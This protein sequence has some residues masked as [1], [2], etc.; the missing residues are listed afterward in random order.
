[1]VALTGFAAA[2]IGLSALFPLAVRAAAEHGESPGPAVSAVS[3]IGYLGFMTGPPV[4]G[5]LAELAGLRA[6]LGFVVLLLGVAVA[7]AGAV[8][9]PVRSR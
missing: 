5:G 3:A 9:A 2:G 8:R 1:M 7:L 4:V 6:G